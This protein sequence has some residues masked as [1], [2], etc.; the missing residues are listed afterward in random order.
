[1]EAASLN[2]ILFAPVQNSVYPAPVNEENLTSMM[3]Y[4]F[5]ERNKREKV[6]S[7]E[8]LNH[9]EKD[10]EIIKLYSGR[11]FSKYFDIDAVVYEYLKIYKTTTHQGLNIKSLANYLNDVIRFLKPKFIS[12]NFYSKNINR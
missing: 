7:T 6:T 12:K 3:Y 4:N 2:K 9:L 1:M 10:E 11:I 8:I 5:S